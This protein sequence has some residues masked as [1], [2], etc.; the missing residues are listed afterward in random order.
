[1]RIEDNLGRAQ[2]RLLCLSPL[3]LCVLTLALAVLSYGYFF[4]GFAFPPV[5]G[6][7]MLAPFTFENRESFE[8]RDHLNALK[9]AGFRA[10]FYGAAFISSVAVL[11]SAGLCVYVL[12]TVGTFLS[13]KQRLWFVAAAL[14]FLL[15]WVGYS[16]GWP[17]THSLL[18]MEVYRESLEQDTILA[19]EMRFFQAKVII[20]AIGIWMALCMAGATCIVNFRTLDP[21]LDT[22]EELRW[23]DG[24]LS[25]TLV[26]LAVLMIS[27]LFVSRAFESWMTEYFED[28]TAKQSYAILKDRLLVAIGLFSSTLVAAVYLPARALLRHRSRVVG[29]VLAEDTSAKGVTEWLTKQGLQTSML[30]NLARIAALAGPAL[31]GGIFEALKGVSGTG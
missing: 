28:E 23:M 30:G 22:A 3:I 29:R 6:K 16:V 17:E 13:V 24:L 14:V 15:G 9:E 21:E 11:T 25:A 31:T 5:I 19:T 4:R 10:E 8:T 7:P 2:K 27:Q 26:L 20:Q 12:S 18:T 1:M